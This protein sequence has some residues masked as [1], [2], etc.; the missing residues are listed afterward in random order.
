MRAVFL[1][2]AALSVAL[3]ACSQPAE[4]PREAAKPEPRALAGVDLDQPV[5]VLGTEPFWAVEITPQGL[6]YSGV[7]RP[8]QKAANPGPALQGTVATWTTKT[9]AGA[10]LAVTLTATDCS[11]GM[12]DRTYPLTAKVEIA[13]ET[14][15]GCAAATAAIERA[16]ESGRVE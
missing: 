9:E 6:T 15:T 10:D 8:E 13:G 12:S 2:A 14:L 4:T 5:R 1:S 3:A 16:G 11:D 7:D